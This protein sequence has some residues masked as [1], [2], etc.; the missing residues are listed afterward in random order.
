MR[1]VGFLF[2]FL[3]FVLPAVLVGLL[4]LKLIRK[5]RASEWK[6][7][8]VDKLYKTKEERDEGSVVK[9]KKRVSHF[10]ILVVR[11][12]EGLTRK[13]AVGKEM[14]DKCQVGDKLVK[15]KGALNPVKA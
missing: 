3:F 2:L 6:G 15:P 12:D 8:I 4:V 7:E 5:T 9:N 1:I 14:Y 10:Y 11:T 13:I